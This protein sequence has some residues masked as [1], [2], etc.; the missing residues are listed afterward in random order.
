V[1]SLL[2]EEGALATSAR[3]KDGMKT[4]FVDAPQEGFRDSLP[5]WVRGL[6]PPLPFEGVVKPFVKNT[7]LKI[8]L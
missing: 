5:F 2:V 1:Q 6:L 4:L 3:V 8:R 7:E